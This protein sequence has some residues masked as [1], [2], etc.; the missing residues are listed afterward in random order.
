MATQSARLKAREAQ[1]ADLQRRRNIALSLP[2]IGAAIPFV[3]IPVALAVAAACA[4]WSLMLDREE[5]ESEKP[6]V[7]DRNYTQADLE[8]CDFQRSTF[9]GKTLPWTQWREKL[10]EV[11]NKKGIVSADDARQSLL[12]AYPG[13]MPFLLSDDQMTRH[14]ALLAATGTGKTELILAIIQQQIKKNAGLI[15]VEAKSDSDFAGAIYG[16]MK[17][18]DRLD[19]FK[20]IN[21]EFPRQSH[22][23]NPVFSGGV[24]ATLS[25]T[26]K[27]QANSKEEFWT[28]VNRYSLTAAILC[29]KLQPGEPAF[30][31]KDLIAMLSSFTLLRQYVENIR[32]TDS[33]DHADGKEFL[34]SYLRYW[35]NEE[36]ETWDTTKY[37]NFL[38]G[39]I[40]K[41]SAF[42]HSEYGQIVNTYS[43]DVDLKE[44]ILNGD[45]VV[46][47]MSS[48][49]DTDGVALF[50]K[51]FISDLAR[52]V[53]EI[54]LEKKK[55]LMICPAIFDEY[56]SFM[57]AS[58]VILFQ[59]A[60]SANVPIIIA[61][62]GIGFLQRIDPAFVE[63]VLG[64]CWTHVY[65]DVKD[66]ATR[67]FACKLAGTC[68]T[69]YAQETEGTSLGSSHSTEQSGVIANES[70]GTSSSKGSKA[71]REDLIQP[72]DF[73]TLDQGDGIII[74]KSG[75]YRVRMPMVRNTFPNVHFSQMQ[76]VRRPRRGR[77]GIGAWKKFSDEN[78]ALINRA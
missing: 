29:M 64:N 19:Q 43:P 28:D 75:T 6:L 56:P 14:V 45:V 77:E 32:E 65:C 74:A 9:L 62:Q 13:M 50:G 47:S 10:T 22:T 17:A 51:L 12:E 27:M 4:Y 11:T 31:L 15:L 18:A 24:R 3:P 55:P 76:L 23:Y 25:T 26:M 44:S 61:F 46:L 60:R 54:Q 7:W 59:L 38:Q 69:N 78:R 71:T 73:Q 63:M 21:F 70:A 20:L 67:E 2:F 68:I 30:H 34:Y 35:Y 36:K 53:G 57:D 40:S 58:Q 8:D 72:E 48:L 37:K 49:A 5:G 33:Q 39:A 41:L 1:L 42:A 52:A 66:A 16:M